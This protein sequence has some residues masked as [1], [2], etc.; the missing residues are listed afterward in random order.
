MRFEGGLPNSDAPGDDCRE[1]G[2]DR[3]EVTA[4]VDQVG[5]LG[6]ILVAG[7]DDR[8]EGD[9]DLF[10]LL[11]RF[12]LFGLTTR[13]GDRV[14]GQRDERGVFRGERVVDPRQHHLGNPPNW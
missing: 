4:R 9:R 10:P 11:V 6:N 14:R 12:E 3:A 2:D 5:E 8:A 7:D 13:E 1:E